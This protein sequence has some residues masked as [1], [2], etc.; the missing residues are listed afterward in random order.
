MLIKRMGAYLKKDIK[1]THVIVY[2]EQ[3]YFFAK[4]KRNKQY[5]V[6][7]QTS[8]RFYSA[9]SIQ[10]KVPI[11]RINDYVFSFNSIQECKELFETYILQNL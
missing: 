10:T 1:R 11:S 4:Q 3:E 9:L 5:Y 8:G 6:F 2:A 7:I